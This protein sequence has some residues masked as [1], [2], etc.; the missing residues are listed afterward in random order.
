MLV[1]L[2]DRATGRLGYGWTYT[3]LGFIC[4]ALLALIYAEMHWGPR[5]RRKREEEKLGMEGDDGNL[6]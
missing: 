3:I 1:A 4:I 2:I 6:R 5:W